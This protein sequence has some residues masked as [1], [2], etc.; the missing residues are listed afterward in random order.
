MSLQCVMGLPHC[1]LAVCAALQC[2]NVSA[3]VSVSV[4]VSVRVSVRASVSCF[5]QQCATMP[6][7]LKRLMELPPSPSQ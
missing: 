5:L 3:S 2:K 4:S 7:S 6:L 1:V